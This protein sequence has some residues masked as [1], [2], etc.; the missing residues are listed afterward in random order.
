MARGRRRARPAPGQETTPSMSCG[1]RPA[2]VIASSAASSVRAMTPLVTRRPTSDWPMPEMMQASSNL[3][4]T[5][6]GRSGMNASPRA[7]KSTLDG[8][9][10]G[11]LVA[12]DD[13]R[14]QA[15][16]G[17]LL[18]LDDGEHERHLEVGRSTAGG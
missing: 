18:E 16:A 1:C 14:D 8:H 3:L 10:D 7:S 11:R 2:S 13:A 15:Q 12:V 6:A 5:R 17:L 9:A 4:M